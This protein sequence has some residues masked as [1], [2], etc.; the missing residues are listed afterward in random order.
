MTQ[1]ESGLRTDSGSA[2]YRLR[3]HGMSHEEADAEV[4]AHYQ[5]ELDHQHIRAT[6]GGEQ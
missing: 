5:Y 1:T 4:R 6:H 3:Q 2:Y